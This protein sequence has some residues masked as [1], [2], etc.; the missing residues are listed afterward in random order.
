[1][2]SSLRVEYFGKLSSLDSHY[3]DDEYFE[4]SPIKSEGDFVHQLATFCFDSC[5]GEAEF[6]GVLLRVRK[7]F[8]DVVA[9]KVVVAVKNRD[10]D[11]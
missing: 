10:H 5:D 11:T 2:K 8:G 6:C 4:D 7:L 3:F 1:M 9:W